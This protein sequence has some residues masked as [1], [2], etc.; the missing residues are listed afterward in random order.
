VKLADFGVAAKLGTPDGLDGAAAVAAAAGYNKELQENVV[1]TPYWMAPEV[2]EMAQVDVGRW[3]G[4]WGRKWN[5]AGG[6]VTGWRAASA[7][8]AGRYQC[9]WLGL[10]QSESKSTGPLVELAGLYSP[11]ALHGSPRPPVSDR[12]RPRRTSGALAA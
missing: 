2:V 11:R 1:G 6:N 5:V 7:I 12:S 9:G 3:C 10:R 4:W 8:L